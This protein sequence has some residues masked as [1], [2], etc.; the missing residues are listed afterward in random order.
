MN[1]LNKVYKE[2][3]TVIN[4]ETMIDDDSPYMYLRSGNKMNMETNNN[5]VIVIDDEL[6]VEV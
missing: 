3:K 5:E 2:W 6:S 1:L 4:D